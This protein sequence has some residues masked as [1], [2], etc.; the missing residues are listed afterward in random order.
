MKPVVIVIVGLTMQ[1]CSMVDKIRTRTEEP[2]FSTAVPQQAQP[3]PTTGGSIYQAGH[4][5]LLF[6]DIKARRIGDILTVLLVERTDA[7][8][9]A[10]TSTTRDTDYDTGSPVFAGRPVTDDGIEILNNV[11]TAEREFTGDADASQSNSLDGSVTVTVA[12]VLANGDL[13]VRGQKKIRL[14]QGDEFIQISGIVRRRDISTE[15]TVPSTR[16]ADAQ[17]IYSGKGTLANSNRP[18][19]LYRFF[20]SPWFPF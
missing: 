10:S 19:W 1:A 16:V 6:E 2:D 17:I 11:V 4:D 12:D 20:N 15:N 18:G 9:N 14:N 7:S 3:V 8:K 13:F 5:V